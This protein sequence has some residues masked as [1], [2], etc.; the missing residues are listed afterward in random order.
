MKA[1]RYGALVAASAAGA[2]PAFAQTTPTG[3]SFTSLTSAID[4]STL[5]TGLLAVGAV[6]IAPR[7]A[8]MGINWIKG[9]VK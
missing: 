2:A 9:S 3:P 1:L 8:R 4:A 5:V 6:M 7:L